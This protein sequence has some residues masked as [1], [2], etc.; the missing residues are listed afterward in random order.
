M[1]WFEDWF[2]SPY[3]KILYSHRGNEE[4]NA[5]VEK[6]ISYLKPLVN[7]FIADI[8]TNSQIHVFIDHVVQ[9]KFLFT[10]KIS[11]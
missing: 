11:F 7:S 1:N 4:A 5:F 8:V 3:Y 10:I 2:N 6:L 9:I